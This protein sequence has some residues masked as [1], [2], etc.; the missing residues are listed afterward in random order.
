VVGFGIGTLEPMVFGQMVTSAKQA[1]DGIFGAPA[2]LN[3]VAKGMA[4]VT[5][6]NEGK[7]VK[8]FNDTRCTKEKEGLGNEVF[9][10]R[11][12]FVKEC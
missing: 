8:K 12:I 9:K 5:L 6:S 10:P 2:E 3:G 11:P 4:T 7:R 1:D